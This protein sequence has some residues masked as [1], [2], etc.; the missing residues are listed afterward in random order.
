MSRGRAAAK[1]ELG[2]VVSTARVRF[3]RVSARKARYLADLVRGLTV[4]DARHQL[5]AVHKPSSM[6]VVAGALKAAMANYDDLVRNDIQENQGD[7]DDLVIVEIFVDAGPML[8]RFRPR[9]MGRAGQIR[10]RTCHL[11]LKLYTQG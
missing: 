2:E 10:K 7:V 11:T 6:P 1:P 4:A 5:G 8:K 3:A 9:A